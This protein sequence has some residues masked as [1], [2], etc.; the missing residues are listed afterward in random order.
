MAMLN[1]QRIMYD[2]GANQPKMPM[3][4]GIDC[5]TGHVIM[6]YPAGRELMKQQHM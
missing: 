1:N 6:V 5:K 3:L 2:I 4:Q